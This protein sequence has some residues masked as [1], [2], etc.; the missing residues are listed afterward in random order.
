MEI[1]KI[2][3]PSAESAQYLFTLV[4]ISLHNSSQHQQA[5]KLLCQRFA[6]ILAK[7]CHA[8]GKALPMWWQNLANLSARKTKA[9]SLS[10]KR[11]KHVLNIIPLTGKRQI[12]SI[13]GQKF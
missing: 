2:M 8:F 6:T 7:F 5:S 4:M 1:H 9:T 12:G 13:N 3:N 11:R 10:A